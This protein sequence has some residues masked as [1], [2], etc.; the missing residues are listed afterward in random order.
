MTIFEALR[1]GS[2]FTLPNVSPLELEF[3]VEYQTQLGIL[4]GIQIEIGIPS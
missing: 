4:I 3:Q 2:P 1:V